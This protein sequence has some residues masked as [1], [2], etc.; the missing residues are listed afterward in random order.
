MGW[1]STENFCVVFIFHVS[2]SRAREWRHGKRH[3]HCVLTIIAVGAI[4]C[5]EVSLKWRI[6][7]LDENDF[8]RILCLAPRVISVGDSVLSG[9]VSLLYLTDVGH[10]VSET[11]SQI[12]YE[13]VI[14]M[15]TKETLYFWQYKA[16]HAGM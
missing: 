7:S 13:T 8:G 2:W 10:D 11:Q 12:L 14:C 5:E 1:H 16:K 9:D 15:K 4:V 6:R 3:G